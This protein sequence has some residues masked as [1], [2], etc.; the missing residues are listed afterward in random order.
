MKKY[1]HFFQFSLEKIDYWKDEFLFTFIRPYW[2]K[3]ITPNTISWIRVGLGICLFIAL[4]FFNYENKMFVVSI[5]LIGIITD[6]IDGPVARAHNQ[7]TEFGKM[8]DPVADR[9]LIVPIAF[10]SLFKLE[11][12]LFLAFIISELL[13]GLVSLFHRSKES[14]ESNIFGKTKMV[15]QSVVFLAILFFWPSLP[16]IFTVMLWVSILFSISSS[17][18]RIVELKNKGYVS[19]KNL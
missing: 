5:F 15:I 8:L 10:Y 17:F 3:F 7:V 11:K 1:F 16:R 14:T 13:A 12:W 4:F 18:I 6:F 2:P 19:L 9:I